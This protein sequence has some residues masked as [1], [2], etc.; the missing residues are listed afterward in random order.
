[1]RVKRKNYA[2]SERVFRAGLLLSGLLTLLSGLAVIAVTVVM[3]I[4]SFIGA[5]DENAAFFVLTLTGFT[6]VFLLL[7]IAA[8]LVLGVPLIVLGI[9][10]MIISREPDRFFKRSRAA[11]WI[12]LFVEAGI[13]AIVSAILYKA[14]PT[15]CAVSAVVFALPILLKLSTLIRFAHRLRSGLVVDPPTYTTAKGEIELPHISDNSAV[16]WNALKNYSAKP[17]DKKEEL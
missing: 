2:K 9:S 12:F 8:G 13:G 10:E 7:F 5:A 15:L 3:G 17:P 6:L 4:A 11:V 1:M 14:D 16:D